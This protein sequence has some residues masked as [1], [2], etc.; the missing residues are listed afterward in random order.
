MRP[1]KRILLSSLVFAVILLTQSKIQANISASYALQPPKTVAIGIASWYSKDSPGINIHTANNEIFD[2]RGLTAAMWQVP[3]HQRVRVTNL[4]NGKSV[5]VR[6]NDR[7]PHERYV[8]KGRIIDLSKRAFS[9]IASLD[10]GLIPIQL[11]FL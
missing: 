5:S 9:D 10:I 3:F 11:E 4:N 7:G 8:Q 2:D 6:I 1:R